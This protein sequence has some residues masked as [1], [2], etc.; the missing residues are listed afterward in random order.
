MPALDAQ[1]KELEGAAEPTKDVTL[2]WLRW[3]SRRGTWFS[4]SS[5][6]LS[7]FSAN[8]ICF[9]RNCRKSVPDFK[10]S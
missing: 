7:H 2:A 1:D 8:V 3:C 4:L 6:F 9:R 5:P 10:P